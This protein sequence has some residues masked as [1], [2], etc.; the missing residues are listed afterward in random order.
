MKMESPQKRINTLDLFSEKPLELSAKFANII[1]NNNAD[2][3]LI[4]ILVLIFEYA[5]LISQVILL[6]PSFQNTSN[7]ENPLQRDI[8][9]ATKLINPSCFLSFTGPGDSTAKAVLYIVMCWLILKYCIIAYICFCIS[10]NKTPRSLALHSFRWSLQ[11]QSRVVYYFASSL[12]FCSII[13]NKENGFIFGVGKIGDFVVCGIF[14]FIEFY[15][16][17]SPKIQFHCIL[18]T[19]IFLSS[20]DNTVE[21]INF[22]Q[23]FLLQI[24]QL[25][26]S[27]TAIASQWI[28]TLTNLALALFRTFQYFTTL[29]L[30]KVKSLFLEGVLIGVLTSLNLASLVHLINDKNTLFLFIVWIILALLSVKIS[31]GLLRMIIFRVLTQNN[32]ASPLFWF[33]KLRSLKSL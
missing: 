21:I 20:K 31:L 8:I 25:S 30:Y 11:L 1:F 5:Q 4:E 24:L 27:Q 2:S 15:L 3:H 9:Y 22:L 16:A 32:L 12:F 33:I 18:P 7:D 29:P 19:K 26:L 14:I 6:Y 28:L 17:M 10:R 13:A 23:K